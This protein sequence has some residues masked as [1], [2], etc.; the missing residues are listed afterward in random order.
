MVFL[1]CLDIAGRFDQPEVDR[2]IIDLQRVGLD[3]PVVAIEV[4]QILLVPLG[5]QIGDVAV[6]VQQVEGGVVFAQ[7]VIVDHVVPDQVGAAQHV[8]GRGHVAP[9]EIAVGTERLDCGELLVVDEVEQFA[10]LL[11]VDLRGEEGRALHLVLLAPA[12][13]HRERRRQRGAR[14][15]IADRMD[16][17]HFQ[18][19]ADMVDRVDLGPHV[20]VPDHVLHVGVGRFPADHEHGHALFDRPAHEAL[21]RVEVED[22]ETV[23]PRREDHQRGGQ[24]RLGC[25]RVLNQ[26]VE[27]RFMDDLAGRGRDVLAQRKCAGVGVRQLPAAQI[28]QQVFHPLDQVLAARLER[29]LHHHRIEQRV[30]RRARRIGQRA[31]GEAQLLA[32]LV[33]QAFSAFDHG[34]NPLGE[35]QVGLMDQRIGGMRA[36]PRIGEA[37]VA[38]RQFGFGR[39]LRGG[40]GAEPVLAQNLLPQSDAFLHQRLLLCRI[41]ERHLPVPVLCQL[42]PPR[43]IEEGRK[44]LR[45][46][47]LLGLVFEPHRLQLHPDIGPVAHVLRRNRCA[48]GRF[49]HRREQRA[50]Q[51]GRGF[52]HVGEGV[53]AVVGHHRCSVVPSACWTGNRIFRTAMHPSRLHLQGE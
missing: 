24:H 19:R 47:K 1:A 25:R 52:E 20:V 10:C 40:I 9:I 48:R 53:G 26:L 18:P 28:G 39:S 32:P 7:Q 30:V 41:G 6:P 11:E 8:E 12:M 34:G 33:R 4:A 46:G 50:R 3:Q 42:H 44:R 43:G 16:L 35:E 31:R 17:R 5:R 29:A 22:V 23:D 13:Q 49:R 37:A 21:L 51:L 2:C 36:P 38:T 45:I 15:A 27:R 14:H